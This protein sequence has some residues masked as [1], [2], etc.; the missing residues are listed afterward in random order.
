MSRRGVQ[1][2]IAL[3][4]LAG[5]LPALASA[6]DPKPYVVYQGHQVRAAP[7]APAPKS[8]GAASSSGASENSAFGTNAVKVQVSP[9]HSSSVGARASSGGGARAFRGVG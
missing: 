8:A 6:D 7:A 2:K 3:I 4:A 1:M 5:L 9:A